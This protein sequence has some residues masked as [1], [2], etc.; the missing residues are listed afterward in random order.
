M[1]VSVIVPTANRHEHVLNLLNCLNR[2]THRPREVLVSAPTRD[3]LPDLTPF[4]GWAIPV[5]GA[6]G[7]SAQRNAAMQIISPRSFAAFFFD[8]DV[9]LAPTYIEAAVRALS[10]DDSLAGVTGT[11]LLDGARGRH[12][13]GFPQ[14]AA[15]IAEAIAEDSVLEVPNLYG[16]NFGVRAPDLTGLPFDE[17]LP[18]YSWLEDLDFSKR[19]LGKRG[20]AFARLGSCV[21]VHHGSSTSGITQHIRLGYSQVTNVAY[22]LVKG[23]VKPAQAARLIYRPVLAN[24]AGAVC[25]IRWRQARLKG[26]MVSVG[27]LLRGRITPERITSF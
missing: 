21:A 9:S 26:N 7:A 15:A 23:S 3:D 27:D 16:C 13:V 18:L 12:P 11:L 4:Q 10:S 17:R 8:D 19:L 25:G 5:V 24:F 6:R 20:G 22:L 2:Q 1:D 14:A